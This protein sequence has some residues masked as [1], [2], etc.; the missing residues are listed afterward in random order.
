M[1]LA[2]VMMA[3]GVTLLMLGLA[4]LTLVA[5]L[6]GTHQLTAQ[7]PADAMARA[8]EQGGRLLRSADMVL[9]PP[10]SALDGYQ[11][12][13]PEGAPLVLRI[14]TPQGPQVIGLACDT[15]AQRLVEFRY[16]GGYDPTRPY[17]PS[18]RRRDLGPADRLTVNLGPPGVL[19]V[20]LEAGAGLPWRTAFSFH[21]VTLR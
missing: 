21:G 13:Y 8:L 2:E 6:R 10:R 5:Y 3:A 12:R 1:V 7:L 11:P 17:P 19:E 20:Q 4:T 18:V 14:R 9:V 16:P 15:G